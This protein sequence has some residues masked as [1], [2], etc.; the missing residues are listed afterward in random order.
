MYKEASKQKTR[1]QTS[2]GMLSVEQLW[3]LSLTELDTLAVSLEEEYK[4]SKGKSFLDKK[5]TKDKTLKLKFDI[6]LE[7]LNDKVAEQEAAATKLKNKAHNQK[8]LELIASKTDEALKGKSLSQLE[9]ML[10]EE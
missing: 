4:N 7:I 8:I 6:V 1:F 2:K 3:D 9:A 5:A 10:L